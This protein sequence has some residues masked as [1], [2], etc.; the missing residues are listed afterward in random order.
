MTLS[1]EERLEFEQA[2]VNPE[3]IER[4]MSTTITPQAVMRAIREVQEVVGPHGSISRVQAGGVRIT[5]EGVRVF[6]DGVN[7]TS[8]DSIGNLFVGSNIEDP[9]STTLAAFVSGQ[10]YN[11]EEMGAGDLLI[12]DNS[13]D[14]PNV[15]YNAV[16]DRLE[17]RIGQ[18]VNIFMDTEGA[19]TISNNVTG[20]SFA[21]TDPTKTAYLKMADDDNFEI[22]NTVAGKAIYLYVTTTD[23]GAPALSWDEDG[24]NANVSQLNIG[25]GSAGGKLSIDTEVVIWA[26]KDGA[27]TFFN[28]GGHDIDFVIYDDAGV[29]AVKVDAAAH[30]VAIYGEVVHTSMPET[31]T[32]AVFQVNAP[33]GPSI[34]S[35][36]IASKSGADV[37]YNAGF[38]GTEAVLVPVST[39]QLAKMR[40]YNTTRGTSALISDCNTGTNTITLTATVPSG[41]VATDTITIASQT[42]SGG[43]ANWIDLEVT[44]GPTNKTE[45]RLATVIRSNVAGD[46]LRVHPFE[47]FAASKVQANQTPVASTTINSNGVAF[48]KMTSNV[49]SIAWNGTFTNAADTVVLRE[50]GYQN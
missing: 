2:G 42:V 35:A 45:L 18:T 43:G 6:E 16:E 39:S 33:G 44:S 13:T 15:K 31:N 29:E 3:T 8:I 36:T 11:N 49:F 9:A 41:W 40:L 5:R 24:A 25:K 50:T 19:L 22:S 10:T 27:S 20:L 37:V 7:K 12:G 26:L 23:E 38:T 30:T 28:G 4:L 14:A 32:N 1:A 34:F 47:T 21:A 48:A 46:I 17:F